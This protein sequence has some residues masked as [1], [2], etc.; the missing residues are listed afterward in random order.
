VKQLHH[1]TGEALEGSRYSDGGR[2]LD[3]HPLGGVDINLQPSSLV[4]GR[5]EQSKQA[6]GQLASETGGSARGWLVPG[7]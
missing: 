6:L 7:V 3:Q 4:D 2:D 5:V 1:K